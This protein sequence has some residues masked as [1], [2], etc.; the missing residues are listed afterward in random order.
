MSS[1]IIITMSLTITITRLIPTIL[2]I[3][4]QEEVT[5]LVGEMMEEVGEMMGEVEVAV[6][7]EDVE[8]VEEIDMMKERIEFINLNSKI[9][10]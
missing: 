3:M 8:E 2:G 5:L 9:S 4:I 6:V 10:F 1:I 7:V